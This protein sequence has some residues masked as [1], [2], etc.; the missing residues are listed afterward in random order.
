MRARRDRKETGEGDRRGRGFT[1]IEL[2]VVVA[3]IA[4]LASLLLPALGRAKEKG[5]ATV[6]LN[7]L[8]QLGMATLMYAEDHRG[9][10]IL[11]APLQRGVTWGSLLATNTGLRPFELFVCPSYPPHRFTNWLTT[12]GVRLDPPEGTT[13]GPFREVFRLEAIGRPTEYLHLADTTSRGREGLGAQQFYFFRAA[14]EYEVHGRHGRLANGFL[15]DGHVEGFN[16]ARLE[17]LGI[18]GLFE[19]DVIPGYFP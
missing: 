9:E 3:V 7:Q 18:I 5:R 10:V 15:L 12:Y 17:R 11:D 2:L 16:A 13:R 6:C 8:R 14:S 4:I 19:R 1:L